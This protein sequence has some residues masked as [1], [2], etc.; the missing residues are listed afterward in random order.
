MASIEEK[1]IGKHNFVG[2]SSRFELS[3]V[4]LFR[5]IKS[6]FRLYIYMHSIIKPIKVG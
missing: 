6:L 1:K 2:A 5:S 4:F 3:S